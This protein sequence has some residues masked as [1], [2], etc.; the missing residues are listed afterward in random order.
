MP[1]KES[2]ARADEPPYL[3][4][5]PR[6]VWRSALLLLRLAVLAYAA[7]CVLLAVFQARLIWIPGESGGTTPREAGLAFEERMLAAAD[8]ERIQAW[9]LPAEGEA[10]G[11]LLFSHGNAGTIE[12]RLDLARF[13]VEARVSVL[14]YDYRGYGL[15]SGS[16]DEDGTYADARAAWK[17]LVEQRGFA[18]GRILL[19][20]ESLGGGVAVQLATE[21]R[22]AGL[23]LH[24]TFRSLDDAA[25]VH[26]PWLPVRLLLRSHYDNAA[27][28]GRI[29][30]PLLVIHSP[31]DEVIPF[32]QGKALFD[33]AAEPKELLV[34][35]GSHNGPS[36]LA[37][38]EWQ[39]R[40]RAFVERALP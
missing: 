24:D 28:I 10:R 35:A 23:V 7:V 33:A 9:F 31:Q 32:E 8:G 12:D 27:K 6:L 38:R 30:A 29:A 19:Y 15:S 11:A 13:F 21:V 17:E 18:P 2:R 4:A 26:Y 34:T 20:G 36:Y 3:A 39:E 22:S 25:A 14:L 37:K 5:M 1:E 16:P 40:V